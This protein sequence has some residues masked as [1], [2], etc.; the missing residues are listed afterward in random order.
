[1]ESII[2]AITIWIRGLGLVFSSIFELFSWAGDVFEGVYGT[3]IYV[4]DFIYPF[5]F[6]SGVLTILFG[7]IRLI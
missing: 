3:L 7:I 4:P 2:N 5:V 6:L 1:M